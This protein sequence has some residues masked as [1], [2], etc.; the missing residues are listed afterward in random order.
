MLDAQEKLF[1]LIKKKKQN[2]LNEINYVGK[3]D[4][5]E[6]QVIDLYKKNLLV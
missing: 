6:S 1:E 3:N 2:K 4:F 5:I